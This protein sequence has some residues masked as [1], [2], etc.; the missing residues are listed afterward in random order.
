MRILEYGKVSRNKKRKLKRQ[1]KERKNS[2]RERTGRRKY[3][4]DGAEDERDEQ[5]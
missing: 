3:C 4:V 1:R 5:E 2:K